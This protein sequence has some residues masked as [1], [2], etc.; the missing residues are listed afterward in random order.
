MP[1]AKAHRK[2]WTEKDIQDAISDLHAG[3]SSN[4]SSAAQ[5]FRVP[6]GTLR[7]RWLGLHES[8]RK[9]HEQR[10]HLS[11]EEERILC[12]WVEH[13]SDIARPL[14]K[15]T[16]LRK[17]ERIIGVRPSKHWYKKFL[18]RH[19]DTLQLGKPSGL[20]PKRAQ[21]FNRTAISEHFVQLQMVLDTKGIPWQNVYNMDE[22]GC[23]RGGG[24]RIQAIKFFIPR[25]RRP[26]Y[27]L[28]SANLEL[29]TIIECVCADG[30]ADVK[31]GFIFPGKEFH[32]EWFDVD[33]DIR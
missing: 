27:K 33:D 11:A 3:R 24:R 32:P 28:C 1:K 31:P 21:C 22:K 17:V 4:V 8:A 30:S 16:L 12:E 18:K 25:D 14:N 26:Q 7:N 29:I 20:D 10:Q 5:K 23:Q 9:A 13:R 19:P 6:H 2:T 15:R